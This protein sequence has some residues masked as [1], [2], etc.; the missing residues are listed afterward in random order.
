MKQ[1]IFLLEKLYLLKILLLLA[2]LTRA[3][4]LQIFVFNF[5]MLQ[6]AYP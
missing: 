4:S 2:E 5:L 6:S 1:L 3:K